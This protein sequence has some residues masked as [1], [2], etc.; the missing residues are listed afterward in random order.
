VPNSSGADNAPGPQ[1]VAG[2]STDRDD[3]RSVRGRL[4]DPPAGQ[5]PLAATG[6]PARGGC[7]LGPLSQGA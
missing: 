4:P 3:L 2:I 1:Q 5:T 7:G 6:L